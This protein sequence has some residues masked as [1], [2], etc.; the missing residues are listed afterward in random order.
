MHI[1]VS[2]KTPYKLYLYGSEMKDECLQLLS[3]ISKICYLLILYMLK[4]LTL[5]NN[6]F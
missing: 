4:T 3:D 6:I 1:K 5:Y 2:Q